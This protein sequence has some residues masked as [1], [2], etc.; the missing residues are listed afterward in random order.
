MDKSDNIQE[1]P[2]SNEYDSVPVIYCRKCLSLKIMVL[3]DNIDYCDEC[4]STEMESTDIFSWQKMYEEKYG[5]PYIR[6]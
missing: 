3:D 1:V 5:K 4:G 2:A 6:E